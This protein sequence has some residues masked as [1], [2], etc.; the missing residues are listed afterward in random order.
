M[1]SHINTS[2]TMSSH[3]AKVVSNDL[4]KLACCVTSGHSFSVPSSEFERGWPGVSYRR[5]GRYKG[6]C[7]VSF[8]Q[9]EPVTVESRT[10]SGSE[11]YSLDEFPIAHSFEFKSGRG[12]K[13]YQEGKLASFYG[14]HTT[15][16]KRNPFTTTKSV[17]ESLDTQTSNTHRRCCQQHA[18]FTVS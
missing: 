12:C 11:R 2:G 1:V 18:N 17:R 8:L 16:T 5:A 9:I 4:R 10:C 6:E 14:A 15:G 13:I 7:I 3:K